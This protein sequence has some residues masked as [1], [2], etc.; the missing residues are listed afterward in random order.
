MCRLNLKFLIFILFILTACN[1][2]DKK[3]VYLI[4]SKN[5]QVSCV[6][7]NNNDRQDKSTSTYNGSMRKEES[8]NN[9]VYFNICKERFLL[10]KD[11]SPETISTS[12]VDN[13]NAVK[14]DYLIDRYIKSD[15]FSKRYVFDKIYFLEKINDEEYLKYEV[16]WEHAVDRGIQN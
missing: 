9:K 4:F 3:A 14:F 2:Q 6:K 5:E 7:F 10:E 15:M 13:L 16:Y 12:D 11:T 1:A 8:S